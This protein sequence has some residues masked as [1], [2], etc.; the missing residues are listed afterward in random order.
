MRPDDTRRRHGRGLRGRG[1][2]VGSWHARG[3]ILKEPVQALCLL[4]CLGPLPVVP[5]QRNRNGGMPGP[6][7]T[8]WGHVPCHVCAVV[9]AIGRGGTRPA[10][11]HRRTSKN[12]FWKITRS[13]LA[14]G[15]H[16][17]MGEERA[18]SPQCRRAGVP[19]C[20]L[21]VSAAMSV[22]SPG[23]SAFAPPVIPAAASRLALV[24][25]PGRW[26]RGCAVG[27]VSAQRRGLVGGLRGA[28]TLT[29]VQQRLITKPRTSHAW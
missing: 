21:L 2:A 13:R 5:A 27:G 28:G 16:T 15:G 14:A 22:L 9:T 1:L 6:A 8:G 18:L 11:R 3:G 17:I 10:R 12:L 29:M 26:G 7:L 19:E 23:V 20:V 25:G 24:S 4:S